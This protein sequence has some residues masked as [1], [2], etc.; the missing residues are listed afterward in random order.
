MSDKALS[1]LT[2]GIADTGDFI[3][4]V[5]GA[6]SRKLQVGTVSPAVA[7]ESEAQAGSN[8]AKMMTPLRTKQA[9]RGGSFFDA[10]DTGSGDR[11]II[12]KLKDY[13]V[14]PEDFGAVGNGATD[15]RA[16]IQAAID[17]ATNGEVL[18]RDNTNYAVGQSG[19]NAWCLQVTNNASLRG[20]GNKACIKP[21][22]A[23]GTGVDTILVKPA[24]N[25]HGTL[26][27]IR[28]L[29]LGDVSNGTRNGRHGIHL[30]TQVASAQ[31]A[32]LEITGCHI[33]ES[34]GT[35]NAIRH[36]NTEANNANGGFYA[37]LIANNVLEDGIYLSK[38]GDSISIRDNIITGDNAGVYADL[39]AGAGNPKI[40]GNNITSVGGGVVIDRCVSPFIF[41]NIFEQT[42]T[43]TQA[44]NAIVD[45]NGATATIDHAV[46]AGNQFQADAG[47]GSPVLVRVAA[48]T[49]AQIFGNRFGTPT[50]YVPIVIT[51]AATNTLIGRNTYDGPTTTYTD[52]GATTYFDYQQFTW[53]PVLTFA[54]PGDLSVTYTDQRGI[55]VRLGRLLFVYFDIVT[56]GFTHTTASGNLNIT[57]LPLT[58]GLAYSMRGGPVAFQGITKANYTQFGATIA[59]GASTMTVNASGSGQPT[60]S[61][62]AADMPTG[63]TV[64][65]RG[66]LVFTT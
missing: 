24:A 55:Y 10:T 56:S 4:G 9:V 45:L 13:S 57:G 12:A 23:V 65:L 17:A 43:S 16:A 27:Y 33:C 53:T 8:N 26:Q 28:D 1:S 48:A 3:Y 39:V 52:G 41:S 35:G 58:N 6:N 18:F 38:S 5:V 44:N 32:K 22:G 30:D 36:T 21:L 61:V 25:T 37:G 2:Q 59:S 62:T 60:A 31:L 42:T 50:D 63:G 40:T 54:T 19:A 20:L 47:T 46:I 15:D 7:T 64:A 11:T 34:S 14:T 29:F 51:A 66:Q 49:G